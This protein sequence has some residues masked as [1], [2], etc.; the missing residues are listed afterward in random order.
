MYKDEWGHKY[1]FFS[2]NGYFSK[3]KELR[4]FNGICCN[5]RCSP[6]LK[7][8]LQSLHVT[9]LGNACYSWNTVR[10]YIPINKLI[11]SNCLINW[12]GCGVNV[13]NFLLEIFYENVNIKQKW[14]IKR[15]N[16][17]PLKQ[18]FSFPPFY[19]L[20]LIR[21]E[22]LHEEKGRVNCRFCC[23]IRSVEHGGEER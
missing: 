8:L 2:L 15:W 21:F 5:A 22:R 6:F 12:N 7:Q 11:W 3:K 16:K 9:C 23:A 18:I 20:F 17:I 19:S 13:K 10:M 14:F 1:L 4:K